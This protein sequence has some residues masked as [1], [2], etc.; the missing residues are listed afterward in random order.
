[1]T[2]VHISKVLKRGYIYAWACSLHPMTLF[3]RSQ[4]GSH[5]QNGC[6]GV[7]WKTDKIIKK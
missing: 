6:R 1:M 2:M 7:H 3:T 5:Q 4:V